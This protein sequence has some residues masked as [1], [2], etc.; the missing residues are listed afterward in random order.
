MSQ[1]EQHIAPS[2]HSRLKQS[3]HTHRA[4]EQS[5]TEQDGCTT[6]HDIA[7]ITTAMHSIVYHF[8]YTKHLTKHDTF[9]GI[10]LLTC[11]SAAPSCCCI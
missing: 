10:L 9:R 4:A 5:R 7:K 8:L 2:L 1:E 6:H 11:S 3:T